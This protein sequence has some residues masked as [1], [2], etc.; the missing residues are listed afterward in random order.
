MEFESDQQLLQ[1]SSGPTYTG[2]SKRNLETKYCNF[3]HFDKHFIK[4]KI[5]YFF[6][7]PVVRGRRRCGDF[8][9]NGLWRSRR[10][11]RRRRRRRDNHR[12]GGKRSHQERL[13][14][15]R[16]PPFFPVTSRHSHVI[17]PYGRHSR[18]TRHQVVAAVI[19]LAPKAHSSYRP[20]GGGGRGCWLGWRRCFYFL[21]TLSRRQTGKYIPRTSPRRDKIGENMMRKG[22]RKVNVFI[23]TLQ[24]HSH[25]TPSYVWQS[26]LSHALLSPNIRERTPRRLLPLR[27]LSS[28]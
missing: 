12:G 14:Q 27:R 7:F 17:F 4:L 5:V 22:R 1:R 26:R 6:T 10:R 28:N 23:W 18:Q 2:F 15:H 16:P 13:G 25:T 20:A 21:S 19:S 3:P 8:S 11:R 9:V 24:T